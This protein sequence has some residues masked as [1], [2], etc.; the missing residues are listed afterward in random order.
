[1]LAQLDTKTVYTFM[2]SMVTI[3]EYVSRAKELGYQALGI[4]DK[5]SLYA[6]YHFMVACQRENVQPLIGCE[7]NWK[8]ADYEQE[9]TTQLVALTTEG[10]RN[11]LKISTAK[12]TGQDDF[13]AIRQYLVDIAVI[14][15]YFSDVAQLD[16]GLDYYIGVTADLPIQEFAKPILPLHTVRFFEEGQLESLQVLHAIRDNVPLNQVGDIDSRQVLLSADSLTNLFIARFPQAVSNLEKLVQGISYHLDT[17]LK[18]PRFNRERLAAEELREKAYQGLQNKQLN[19]S[20]YQERLERELSVIHEMGFDDYFLIVWDLL[21]FGRSQ[22]YY[23]GMGRGSAVGSLVAYVLN[24]TGIDPVKHNLLFERFLNV[25]RYSMPDIDIDIPDIHRS[26]FI[27]YVRDR[28]GSTHAAQIVTYSTFGAKQAIRDVFKRFG[29]PEYELTNITKKISFR[30][31]LD[32]AYQRNASFR[33]IINSK[34]EY[35]KAFAIAQQIEGQPRQ[36]SIHAAGVVMSDED[37]TDTI[38]L[39]IGDDMLVT[40]YDAHAVEA[41]GLLKMDF[42]GLRN[43]TFVQKMAE[44][45]REQYQ[46][47][48]DI[49]AIN[50]EDQKTLELFAAGQTKGIFQFEQ[51]GAVHLLRRVKPERFEEV[52][53][54]TSLNRPGASDY[55][56]NFVKRKHGQET[57]DLLDPSIAT[58][59]EPTYGI[60]LYQEQV[61]QIAQ[62]YAGFTLG[63]ADLLR[64]AMSKKNAKEMQAMEADFLAGA[65]SL[66]H[67]EGKAREIFAMM[68]KFAGYGFNRSHAY[69]YSALAFQMAYFKTHYPDVFFTVMLNHS[70]GNYI[71]DALQFNF[72]VGKLTI[73]H[74]PYYDKVEQDKIYLGLKTLKGFPKDLALWILEHRPYKSVEDFILRLPDNYKKKELLIP[75]IQI[76]LFD[77]FENNRRKILENLDNLLVFVEAIGSFFAEDTYSWI[78]AEDYSDSEKFMMEQ[79]LMGVGISPH[80]LVAIYQNAQRSFVDLADLVAGNRA[81]ILVQMQSIRLIRTKK[82]G[83]QMA[84]LQVTDT[85]RKLDVT[86]FPEAYRQYGP[87]LEEGVTAYI[88]GRIQERDGRLQMVLEKVEPISL[89]KFWI[90][91]ENKEH[92]YAVARILEKYKGPIPVVLHYQDSNQTIQA[93]RYMVMKTPQLEAD[94]AEF[95]MKTIFR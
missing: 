47:E 73:N 9:I 1:M 65:L 78:E 6:A 57:I 37:L 61:M 51:P 22:G 29:T 39:K 11:L 79:E 84:F 72:K 49:A 66:G 75:L 28:Y 81:T 16:L 68:A 43:L 3:E 50:L 93:E 46:K 56:D 17:G 91:L 7:L 31:T 21:R 77:E 64:R 44:G 18:L 85:K 54:T 45:V 42:L 12:M 27:R 15:P 94:L 35:K 58:I 55:S 34:I 13:E 67:K 48:I 2:D 63:K 71:E 20:I 60:M 19:H 89:E 92:D 25:E 52:V 32:S 74:V 33:Q 90:L 59:L 87:V 10:Y 41:N 76:G 62:T 83:E 86:L 5:N 4:M 14:V 23:M 24:I 8:L 80:P 38:P 30:D 53:A 40:Q 88:T 82:T 70:S 26:D 95:A 36:T 69:A